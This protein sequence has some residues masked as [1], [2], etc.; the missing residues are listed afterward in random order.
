M[1]KLG[2]SSFR[3]A[4]RRFAVLAG[5]LAVVA[6]AVLAATAGGASARSNGETISGAGSTFVQPLVSQ[7]ISPVGS[8]FGIN[9]QY[10]GVGSGAGITAVTNRTVDFG[11]S[12]APLSPDQ[13]SACKGCVQ[14]P[15]A[16]SATSIAYNL[17]GINCVLRLTG[18]VLADIYLG[19]V[20]A[21]DDPAIKSLNSKCNLPGT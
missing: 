17:P 20:S 8:A 9:L 3:G 10:S 7:W 6:A 19:K 21:W 2:S 13:F 14:I 18:P 11:A 1:T 5:L 15:W 4:R 16:L 12:D